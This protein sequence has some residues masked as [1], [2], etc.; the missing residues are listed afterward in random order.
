MSK[1]TSN[2]QK[3]KLFIQIEP[4]KKAKFKVLCQENNTTVSKLVNEFID[5]C[6][7]AKN[8]DNFQLSE[9]TKNNLT[10]STIKLMIEQAIYPLEQK[11]QELEIKITSESS[12]FS[13]KSTHFEQH[14]EPISVSQE[15]TQL[16]NNFENR[17]YLTRH[18]VWKILKNTHYVESN[19]YE[20]FLRATPEELIPYDIYYDQIY[21]RY[22]LEEHP[23][24]LRLEGKE[25]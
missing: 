1:N 7:S 21:K 18:Q 10:E 20:S 16:D 15:K 4:E 19:G 8:F 3:N 14:K 2:N 25:M 6:L 11:I 17:K 9:N 23:E 22:Y 24:N 12:H 13:E 5:S